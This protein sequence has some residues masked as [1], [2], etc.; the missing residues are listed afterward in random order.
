[1]YHGDFLHS[2]SDP[3]KQKDL[4]GCTDIPRHRS[5][6]PDFRDRDVFCCSLLVNE[7]AGFF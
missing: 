4:Q 5:L 7:M 6:W 1:M 3:R 2:D